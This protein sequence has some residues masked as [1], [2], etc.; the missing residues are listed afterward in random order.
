[1]SIEINDIHI[2]KSL[3]QAFNFY[4]FKKSILY[5]ETELY[6]DPESL[7]SIEKSLKTLRIH[8]RDGDISVND[9]GEFCVSLGEDREFTFRSM[10]AKDVK[11][12]LAFKSGTKNQSSELSTQI[13]WIASLCKNE[14]FKESDI[15]ELTMQKLN[16]L[17]LIHNLFFLLM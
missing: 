14:E 9:L 7:K 12:A 5:G 13:R 4:G 3:E 17:S 6:N 11:N 8:M 1:M 16:R 2:E 10:T 15:E